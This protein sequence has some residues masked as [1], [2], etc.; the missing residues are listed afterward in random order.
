MR[1]T[2]STCSGAAGAMSLKATVRSSWATISDLISPATILQKMQSG[3]V[4][5]AQAASSKTTVSSWPAAR[6]AGSA[7][8]WM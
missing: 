6:P 7:E 4:L 1:G 5:K 2:T 8:T 3:L